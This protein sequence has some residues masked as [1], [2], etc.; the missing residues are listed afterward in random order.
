MAVLP[1]ISIDTI[2]FGTNGADTLNGGPGN[3]LIHAGAGADTLNGRGGADVLV[4]DRG[5]DNVNGGT[6]NDAI[7]WTNGDG[8]DTVD[9]GGGTDTQVVEGSNTGERFTL[10]LDNGDAVFARVTPNAFQLDLQRVEI[11]DLQSQGGEDRFT[12]DDLTGSAINEVHFRGGDGGDRLDGQ[13]SRTPLLAEGEAGNDRLAGGTAGDQLHGGNGN[14]V[15]QGNGGNDWL[16][17]GNGNDDLNGGAGRDVLEG[18]AGDDQLTGGNGRDAFVFERN[19]GNDTINDFNAG[20]DVIVLKGF[21]GPNGGPLTFNDLTA[22]ITQQ[23]TDTVIDV[24][25]TSI[26]V[27]NVANLTQTDFVF[28]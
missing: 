23:G 28:V 16:L 10:S 4:G 3:D 9:G 19:G 21:T 8:S 13:N 15:L 6:G 17:G 20:N 2:Q 26:T 27:D 11:V 18:G 1:S 24:G 5:A 25:N 14:D 7:L 12:V 22:D